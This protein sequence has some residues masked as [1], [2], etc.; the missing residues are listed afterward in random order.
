[1]RPKLILLVSVA[2]NALL[3]FD[4]AVANNIEGV[5]DIDYSAPN[6]DISNSG[7]TEERNSGGEDDERDYGS[8]SVMSDESGSASGDD[9]MSTTKSSEVVDA[10]VV[11]STEKISTATQGETTTQILNEITD[12]T[13][14]PSEKSSDNSVEDMQE[15][16][17]SNGDVDFGG[18]S[19]A[20]KGDTDTA[21]FKGTEDDQVGEKEVIKV[22]TTEV[23]AAVVVGAVCAV[24]LIAFLVY[25]LRKR[26]EG[27]YALSDVGYK[28]T[29]RLHGDNEKEAFV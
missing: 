8:G 2:L 27:S 1:M 22:L 18:V 19:N 26:D 28:D 7:K 17:D 14:K 15:D 16:V 12:T 3:G 20:N 4:G 21:A 23:I 24:V 9:N 29:Y 11:S 6:A 13:E 10:S 25:R 5:I